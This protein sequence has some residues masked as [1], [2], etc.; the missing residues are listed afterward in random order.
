MEFVAQCPSG[1]ATHTEIA[2]ALRIPKSSLTGLLRDLTGP[3]YL[4]YEEGSGRFSIGSQVM[5]LA[6]SYL[7]RLN[8]V[9]D[10]APF[11]HRIFLEVGEFTTMAIPKGDSCVVVC[12]ENLPSPL[13]HSLNIGEHVPMLPSALGK[14]MLAFLGDEELDEYLSS[15]KPVSYTAHT[16]MKVKDI[17]QELMQIREAGFAYGREEYLGGISGIAAPVFNMNGRPIASVGVA[18]PTARMTKKIEEKIQKVLLKE[19]AALSRRLGFEST[20]TPRVSKAAAY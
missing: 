20:D 5:F 16:Q 15:H 10:G 11:V 1:G 2:A 8:V 13:A 3:G 12:A 6:H 17:R 18:L 9:R 7:K 14:A 19:T 4:Q